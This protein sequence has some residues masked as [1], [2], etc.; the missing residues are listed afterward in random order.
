M[1]ITS[2]DQCGNNINQ[3][4]NEIAHNNRQKE[5]NVEMNENLNYEFNLCND[6]N[7]RAYH[8][9]TQSSDQT[10]RIEIRDSTLDFMANPIEQ[11]MDK[12]AIV[13]TNQY[14]Q[15]PIL[16]RSMR[17][18]KS[19]WKVQEN[20]ERGLKSYATYYEAFKMVIG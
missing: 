7:Q 10:D 6:G 4:K 13:N 16:C 9:H 19:A 2:E 14:I 17:I 11:L 8:Q 1:L 20:N 18:K 5:S 3:N 12:D 15:R